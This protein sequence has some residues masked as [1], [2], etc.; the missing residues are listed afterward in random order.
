METVSRSSLHSSPAARRL[1]RIT[2][3]IVERHDAGQGRFLFVG[4]LDGKPVVN[5]LAKGE[6][7]AANRFLEHN[8]RR[9]RTQKLR[10]QKGRCADCARA[11][12]LQQHHKKKRSQGRDD[13]PENLI[14]LCAECHKF[15]DP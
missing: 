4:W 15:Y 1:E 6:K 11:R 9:I 12:P 5:A 14:L 8:L 7:A 3:L 2:G 10:E 13:R